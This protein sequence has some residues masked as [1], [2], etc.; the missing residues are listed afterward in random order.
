MTGREGPSVGR[1]DLLLQL[2]EYVCKH[3]YPDI[4]AAHPDDAAARYLAMYTEIVHR[5]ALLVAKWQLVGW[6]H[7]MPLIGG[8]SQRSL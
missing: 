3:F 2:M 7:G 6:T 5:T 8:A 4:H 1:R